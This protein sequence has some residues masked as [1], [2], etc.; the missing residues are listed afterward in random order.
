MTD[1]ATQSGG[2]I[3]LDTSSGAL[4]SN[5]GGGTSLATQSGGGINLATQSVA[6]S[7]NNEGG[8]IWPPNL[9][10]CLST[11]GGDQSGHHECDFA[12]C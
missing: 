9:V 3:H 10:Q 6:M 8:P 4:S 12:L 1:L 2:A 7:F 11:M 5:R